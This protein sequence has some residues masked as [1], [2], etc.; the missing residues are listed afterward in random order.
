MEPVHIILT[1]GTID[2]LYNPITETAEPATQSC[3]PDYIQEVIHPYNTITYEALC[4]LDSGEITEVWRGLILRAIQ[5][6]QARRIVVV[7]GTNTMTQTLE[8][9]MKT[10]MEKTVVL[11]GAMIP[12]KQF[13]LSDGGFNLGYALAQV[14]HLS[15]GVY[16]CMHAKTF[17]AGTVR[18]NFDIARFESL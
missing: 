11:T 2:S 17:K 14:Q 3:I 4:M 10:P 15:A 1:G 9:L 5:N 18:K 12:L 7:H 6:T 16:I 8:F 13:A